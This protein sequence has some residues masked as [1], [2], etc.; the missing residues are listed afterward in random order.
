MKRIIKGVFTILIVNIFFFPGF[1][2]GYKIDL[3]IEGLKDTSVFIAYHFGDKKFIH[4]TITLDNKGVGAFQGD[5]DL[6]GG[7]YLVVFPNMK[8]FEVLVSDDQYFSCETDTADLIGKLKFKGSE[9]NNVF[10][11][12]Q[13]FMIQ[14]QK[15][16]QELRKRRNNFKEMPDSVEYINQ[17]LKDQD[18]KV[19]SYWNELVNKHPNT[20]LAN[21]IRSMIPPEMPEFEI[22]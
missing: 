2:Q 13:R 5:K 20:F 15:L 7:V 16:S 14:Q 18:K 21:L 22:P 12:Y 4:D 8:F 1:S 17:Q 11:D 10:L 3:K 9:E 19:K 6:P